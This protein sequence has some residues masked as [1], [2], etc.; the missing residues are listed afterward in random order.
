MVEYSVERSAGN[1]DD[2]SANKRVA[3]MENS[4]VG[5]SDEKMVESMD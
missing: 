1:S 3:M 5:S 4:T 2:L